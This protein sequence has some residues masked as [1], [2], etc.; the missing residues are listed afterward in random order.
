MWCA[1]ADTAGDNSDFPVP[2]MHHY[3]DW[4]ISALNR[5]LPYDEF[6]RAQI[7]GDLLPGA[8]EE[9]KREKLI[10]T[11]YIANSRRFGSRVDDYPQHLTIEDTI[12]N[13]GR[14]F[15]RA[16]DQLRPLPRPQVRPDHRGGLLRDLRHLPQHALP[17]AGHRA[18]SAAARFH[19]ARVGSIR[20][21]HSRKK[22]PEKQ[23]PLGC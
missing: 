18:R 7:A 22:K 3:R 4:V 10:A 12:D 16:D 1:T 11:G 5:D 20:S 14:T 2:Q 8:S 17:V 19:P 6:V 15:P 21:P 9:E 23:K 13:F